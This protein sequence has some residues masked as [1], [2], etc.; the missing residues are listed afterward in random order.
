MEEGFRLLFYP[1][2]RVENFREWE[3]I[4]A[5]LLAPSFQAYVTTHKIFFHGFKNDL[6]TGYW[7]QQNFCLAGQ[8]IATWLCRQLQ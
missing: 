6:G 7:N 3:G 1:D 4:T 8:T 5:L 2:R